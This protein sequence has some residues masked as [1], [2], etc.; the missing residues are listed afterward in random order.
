MNNTKQFWTLFRFQTTVNPFIWFMPV[1]FGLPLFVGSTLPN[2]YHATLSSLITTQNLFFVGIFGTMVVAPERFMI[3]AAN[4]AWNPGTEFLL[5]R[6]VD[7]RILYR[8]KATFLYVLILLM[9]LVSIGYSLDKPDLKVIEYSDVARQRCL[10]L[11][12]GSTLEK[13]PTCSSQ[14][15][16]FGRLLSPSTAFRCSS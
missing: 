15:G 2:W 10:A 14:N 8:S 12:P 7:R 16:T 3:G 5:T 9:P 13:D 11:V 4:A 6:A 1:A